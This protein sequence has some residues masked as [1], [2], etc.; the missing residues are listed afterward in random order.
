MNVEQKKLIKTLIVNWYRKNERNSVLYFS[1]CSEESFTNDLRPLVFISSFSRIFPLDI[2]KFRKIALGFGAKESPS[3]PYLKNPPALIII[4][5]FRNSLYKSL[6]RARHYNH[7][8][9]L[10]SRTSNFRASS[11]R[12]N[13]REQVRVLRNCENQNSTNEWKN[14]KFSVK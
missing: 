1:F 8:F 3:T 4:K 12:E 14:C 10:N 5:Y 9:Y 2:W 11:L 6:A 13:L 7:V